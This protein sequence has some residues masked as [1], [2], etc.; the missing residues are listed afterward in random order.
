MHIDPKHHVTPIPSRNNGVDVFVPFPDTIV[1]IQHD[2][3][4]GKDIIRSLRNDNGEKDYAKVVRSILLA[5]FLSP[6]PWVTIDF[7]SL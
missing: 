7:Y 2:K 6:F 4:T 5:F 1:D 3:E